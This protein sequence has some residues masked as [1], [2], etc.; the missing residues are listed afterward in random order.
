MSFLYKYKMVLKSLIKNLLP[1]KIIA[2]ENEEKKRLKESDEEAKIIVE[3]KHL[4]IIPYTCVY[5]KGSADWE[6]RNNEDKESFITNILKRRRGKIC[7]YIFG[8]LLTIFFRISRICNLLNR[9]Q[10]RK[11]CVCLCVCYLKKDNIKTHFSSLIQFQMT[12]GDF[13]IFNSLSHILY[14]LSLYLFL[15][16]P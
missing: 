14:S 12:R 13:N 7:E 6:S 15:S 4:C 16:Q 3:K 10:T 1:K 11:L 8:R 5:L 2:E 9:W